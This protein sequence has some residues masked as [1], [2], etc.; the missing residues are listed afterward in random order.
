MGE[1]GATGRRPWNGARPLPP[2]I[3][4]ASRRVRSPGHHR[5]RRRRSPDTTTACA[6]SSAGAGAPSTAFATRRRST[7]AWRSP[8]P[9]PPSAC[10][11]RSAS[12]RRV[13]R[14]R[15]RAPPRR[16]RRSASAATS[17]RW[18]SWSAAARRRRSA[19][20]LEH[21]EAWPRDVG[22]PP[23]P[24][25]HLVLAGPLP[26]DPRADH[27]PPARLRRGLLRLGAPRVRPRA[28]RPLPGGRARGRDRH[29]A[30][31]G[32]RLGDPRARARAL[33]DGRVRRGRRSACRPRSIP[34]SVSTGSATISSGTWR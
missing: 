26:G 31:P 33:R 14:R 27:A 15:P 5:H 18:P 17:R 25:L 8:T 6:S 19:Q 20:M 29:R 28:G 13:N 1:R 3:I 9:A 7:R 4:D 21:L 16:P 2:T 34:A 11:W 24:L 23:A 32:G 30:E 22:R 12:R 10:S